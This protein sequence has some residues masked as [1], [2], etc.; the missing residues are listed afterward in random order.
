MKIGR[1][2][3][4]S[5]VAHSAGAQAAHLVPL[6]KRQE[7]GGG[8]AG[9]SLHRRALCSVTMHSLELLACSSSC[10]VQH[11]VRIESR[12]RQ[13]W[14]EEPDRRHTIGRNIHQE[15]NQRALQHGCTNQ[16]AAV[17]NRT[18]VAGQIQ[19][20]FDPLPLDQSNHHQIEYL[21]QESRYP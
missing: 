9:P 12:V 13:G 19:A 5:P 3:A 20:L 21:N 2:P 11:S 18:E 4:A 6:C 7:G 10:L 17:R 1:W 8:Q 14:G 16:R 15:A